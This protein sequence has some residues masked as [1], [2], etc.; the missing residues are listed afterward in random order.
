MID[1]QRSEEFART[2]TIRPAIWTLKSTITIDT[3]AFA[4]SNSPSY[5]LHPDGT[6][7]EGPLC[8]RCARLS[9]IEQRESDHW[10]NISS[11][12]SSFG[13]YILIQDIAGYM[14]ED[15]DDGNLIARV[16]DPQSR[17]NDF[18]DIL[19]DLH[20]ADSPPVEPRV[21]QGEDQSEDF[22]CITTTVLLAWA[23]VA[24]HVRSSTPIRFPNRLK[25]QVNQK[26]VPIPIVALVIVR[27]SD[28]PVTL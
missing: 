17:A 2:G 10:R 9:E 5:R 26:N 12:N 8:F 25:R 20:R 19:D 7:C 24:L 14:S 16:C 11:V 22:P 4:D 15:S 27:V 13:Q 23:S 6:V 18:E 1:E 28:S 3:S 21:M